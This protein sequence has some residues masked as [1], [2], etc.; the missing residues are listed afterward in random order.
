MPN[1]LEKLNEYCFKLPKAYKP[2]MR[3]DGVIYSCDNLLEGLL[4][5]K[6]L[7]QVANVAFLPGIVQASLA[8]PDIHWGY[9]FPIGGVAA[10]NIDKNGVI[11]PGG[12][13]FDINCGVRLVKTGLSHK[14]IAKHLPEL[15]KKLY[16]IIP[17]GVGSKG[18]IRLNKKELRKILVKGAAWAVGQGFGTKQDLEF[19]EENGCM[20][21]AEPDCISAHALE[22]GQ[23]QAGTLGAGN[24]FLELQVI[25]KI[26]EPQICS[27]LGLEK[28]QITI[29]IHTGSRGFGHQVCT[30]YIKVMLG[31]LSKFDINVPDRQLA[32]APVNSPEGQEYLGAMGCAANYAWCNR[33]VLMHLVRDVFEKFF[34]QSRQKLKMNLIYDVAH[35]IAK[36]ETHAIDGR[37]V[38][39]CVHRKGA[40]RAFGP[41]HKDIPAR[42]R[43]FG[44][45]VIIPG[46]MGRNSY[47]LCG[48][49]KAMQETFGSTCHGAGRLK[50]RSQAIRTLDTK[51]VLSELNQKGIIVHARGRQTISEEAPQAYKDINEIVNVVHNAGISKKVCRMRPIGVIKG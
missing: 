30:D 28:E 44:Q 29:M 10:T 3:V 46:D 23:A 22:R 49:E 21:N 1:P 14:E 33:Q 45:P 35:N 15:M 26:Y 40:T 48:T 19:T 32:C 51:Q 12:V 9:G 20:S 41:G 36:I 38:R 8:M 13:G 5:D 16:H 18:D 4:K 2:G 34:K 7:E 27:E 25:D 42:Y 50:S 47:L 11:S 24:H 6:A 37:Q 31:C 43:K 39:L 17:A